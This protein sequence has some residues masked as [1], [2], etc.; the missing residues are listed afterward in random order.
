MHHPPRILVVDDGRASREE[1]VG[2]LTRAGLDASAVESGREA[3]R[4]TREL[5]PDMVLVDV[6]MPE[7]DGIEL[8]RLL[9]ASSPPD[10][11]VPVVLISVKDDKPARLEALRAGADDFIGRPYD[12]EVLVARLNALLRIKAQQD[13]AR[14]RSTELERLSVTDEL[15]GVYNRRYFRE[16]LR[17]EFRR[18]QRYDDPLSL[19]ILDL[20]H[21]KGVNDRLGHLA[22]DEV[23][24][25]ATRLLPGCVRETD[26]VS[27]YGGEEFTILLPQTHLSG[28]LTVAERIWRT[29]RNHPFRIA[30]HDERLTASVGVSSFPNKGVGSPEDLLRTADDALYRA[31]RT[32]R[33]K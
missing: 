23:L 27:R 2:T 6:V 16:R 12:E 4:R 25:Q 31:K 9:K 7:M 3:L 19:I 5:V 29:L 13:R 10:E 24:R 15:T 30:E 21:F 22:G 14:A 28:C 11:F 32:G 20:D 26:I 17:E 8:L 1:L 33:D 18:A